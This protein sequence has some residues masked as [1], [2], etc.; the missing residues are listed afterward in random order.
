MFNYNS[1][2]ALDA[3]HFL[4]A[5]LV[6]FARGLNDTPKLAALLLMVPFLSTERMTALIAIAM[7]SGGLIH[8]RR[9]AETMSHKV[10]SM[11]SKQGFAA[12]FITAVVVNM[13]SK[14]QLPVSTTHVSVGTLFGVGLQTKS[15]N[16]ITIRSILTAWIVTLPVAAMFGYFL[17]NMIARINSGH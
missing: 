7:A 8:S 4:S 9:I 3:L 13:R 10:T 17:F 14:F 1:A 5:G 11:N 12:N 15:A 16:W 6:C 2:K